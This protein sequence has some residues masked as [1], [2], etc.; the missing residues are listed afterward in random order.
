MGSSGQVRVGL[1]GLGRVGKLH[2]AVLGALPGGGLAAVCAPQAGEVAAMI[3]RHAQ[4]HG[5][6]DF[7]TMLDE[8][9][10]DAVFIVSPEPLHR[11]QVLAALGRSIATFVEKPLA[12]TAV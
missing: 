3:G 5:F 11:D 6:A 1:A 2:A 4:A 12:M 10:L 7:E 8:S 9:D